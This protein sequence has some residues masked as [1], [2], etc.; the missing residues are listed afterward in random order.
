MK[1]IA[2]RADLLAGL[3]RVAS[4][5]ERKGL[6]PSLSCV[7]LN[8]EKDILRISATDLI[9]S[10]AVSVPITE[11]KS[12]FSA[13]L[14]AKDLIDRIK[15]MPTGDIG[16]SFDTKTNRC[17]ITASGSPRKYVLAGYDPEDFPKLPEANWKEASAITSGKLRKLIGATE[18]AISNDITRAHLASLLIE[19]EGDVIRAVATDGHR[20]WKYEIPGTP[21]SGKRSMLIPLKGVGVIGA[22][23]E[24]IVEPEEI[25]ELDEKGND[26]FIRTGAW[27]CCIRKVDA[28][29]PPYQQVIP[30][31]HPHKAVISRLALI[32]AVRSVRLASSDT[33]GSVAFHLTENTMKLVAES[34]EK[35]SGTDEVSCDYSSKTPLAIG[36]NAGYID[37]AL[38]A[39][40]AEEVVISLGGELDP[41]L[42]KA[43]VKDPPG[44]FVCMPL[45]I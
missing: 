31:N 18:H 41:T 27:S 28:Q 25:V 37:D 32:D 24:A 34:A 36:F 9:V 29:F 7:L 26:L 13:A 3:A 10:V 6:V 12:A 23:M 1:L 17:T 19:W 15:A 45:R 21:C 14:P 30:K 4:V 22:A 2:K 16:L 43:N 38:Q 39:I 40:D 5:P 42:L 33:S 11:V 20:L 8:A 35:G 44:E